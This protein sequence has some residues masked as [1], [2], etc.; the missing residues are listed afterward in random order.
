MVRSEFKHLGFTE[1]GFPTSLCVKSPKI[2]PVK[3]VNYL[4]IIRCQNVV[5]TA[6][7]TLR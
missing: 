2:F 7:R 3:V 1:E 4:T 5:E 6:Q